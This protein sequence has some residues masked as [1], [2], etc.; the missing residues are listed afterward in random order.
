VHKATHKNKYKNKHTD[1]HKS[2]THRE[3]AGHHDR[4]QHTS[5]ST[6]SHHSKPANAESKGEAKAPSTSVEKGTQAKNGFGGSVARGARGAPAHREHGRVSADGKGGVSTN[7]PKLPPP[8]SKDGARSNDDHE[9]QQ[10]QN[11]YNDLRQQLNMANAG[12][13]KLQVQLDAAHQERALL[14]RA[15]LAV[16]KEANASAAELF[17]CF[18]RSN[19]PCSD[20]SDPELVAKLRTELSTQQMLF[21][22]LLCMVLAAAGLAVACQPGSDGDRPRTYNS[23]GDSGNGDGG[24]GDGGGSRG[25]IGSGRPTQRG[26]R[27]NKRSKQQEPDRQQTVADNNGGGSSRLRLRLR[28]KHAA[29]YKFAATAATDAGEGTTAA[30]AA[31]PNPTDGTSS[32]NAGTSARNTGTSARSSAESG[33]DRID[34]SEAEEMDTAVA[35]LEEREKAMLEEREKAMLDEREK[36]M[37]EESEKAMLEERSPHSRTSGDGD[38]D[39][40]SSNSI[41]KSSATS[42]DGERAGL[43]KGWERRKMRDGRLLYVHHPTQTTQFEDP[44]KETPPP[45]EKLPSLASGLPAPVQTLQ[46]EESEVHAKVETKGDTEAEAYFERE[47]AEGEA[48]AQAKLEVEEKVEAVL[49]VEVRDPD[50]TKLGAVV[51]AEREADSSAAAAA[52]ATIAS[53]NSE[54]AIWAHV[55]S[56]GSVVPLSPSVLAVAE[57]EDGEAQA[58]IEDE[59]GEAQVAVED[60]LVMVTTLDCDDDA[61]SA[62]LSGVAG[63]ADDEECT[64]KEHPET[65]TCNVGS[66]ASSDED[67]WAIVPEASSSGQLQTDEDGIEDGVEIECLDERA[68]TDEDEI[69][70]GVETEFLDEHAQIEEDGIE[71]GV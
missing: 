50:E 2:N 67:E 8:S 17:R 65:E 56:I 19:I 38:T 13:V 3:N 37:L 28:N 7:G 47:P 49:S 25:S 68:Q 39:C 10:R 30:A 48:E 71:D 23:G 36:A 63:V 55:A 69:E 35:L 11:V 1:M 34:A 44:R 20:R 14:E 46:A 15:H 22:G 6:S 64:D 21:R 70:D 58:L 41:A 59:D 53:S 9:E 40:G 18:A 43:P 51:T 62:D 26:M 52:S 29:T 42:T 33:Q 45:Y 24:G 4:P 54:T 16:S 32:R 57:D 12:Q 66:A 60:G 61:A 31:I 27:S 5:D